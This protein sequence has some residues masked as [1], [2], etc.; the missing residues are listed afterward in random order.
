MFELGPRNL[1]F[2]RLIA[3][4]SWFEDQTL[5]A[6]HLKTEK[7]FKRWKILGCVSGVLVP[8]ARDYGRTHFRGL[9]NKAQ[10]SPWWVHELKPLRY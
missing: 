9:G 5:R 7:K 1:Y 3:T 6:T 10:V 2:N 4:S 8:S